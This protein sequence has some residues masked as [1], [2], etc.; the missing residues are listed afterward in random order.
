MCLQ[1]AGGVLADLQFLKK[2]H[3]LIR[4]AGSMQFHGNVW[5]S[6]CDLATLRAVFSKYEFRLE[7]SDRCDQAIRH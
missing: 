1:S 5:C 4:M 6:V 2:W 3:F 7:R